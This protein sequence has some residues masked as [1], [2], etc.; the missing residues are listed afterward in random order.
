MDR[1]RK[2]SKRSV[3][4]SASRASGSASSK[5]GRYASCGWP[6]P[7]SSTICGPNSCAIR[8]VTPDERAQLFV[9]LAGDHLHLAQVRETPEGVELDLA[10]SLAG[11]PEPLADLLQGLG[12]LVD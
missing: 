1:L 12:L 8:S 6:L 11:E 2:R 7:G 5:R 4:S 3:R 10:D 9:R